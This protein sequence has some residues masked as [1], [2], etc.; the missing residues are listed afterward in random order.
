MKILVII[1]LLSISFNSFCQQ[2]IL[3][4]DG[5]RDSAD[6]RKKYVMIETANLSAKKLYDNALKYISE[7]NQDSSK[8]VRI[9]WDSVD[10]IYDSYVYYL[11][12]TDYLFHYV[13]V[14]A[15]YSTE[16]RF[17]PGSVRCEVLSLDMVETE[18][19]QKL[20]FKGSPVS[21]HSIY[22]RQGKLLKPGMK[23]KIEKYFN[24]DLINIAHFLNQM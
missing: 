22:N 18:S 16:L 10:I 23:S 13:P 2:W 12:T 17:Y 15:Y 20:V 5:L 6:S 14:E 1:I 3:T 9:Q 4:P 24:S 8:K 19:G 7:N 11:L 21:S